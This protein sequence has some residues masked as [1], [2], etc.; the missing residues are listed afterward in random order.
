MFGLPND[1]E[2]S[3]VMGLSMGGYGALKC[4]LTYP[5]RYAGCASFSA[6]CDM[7][8]N[9]DHPEVYGATKE[10]TQGVFGLD[11]IIGPENDVFA[12]AEKSATAPEKPRFFVSCGTEDV[13]I[14]QN[15]KF[16]DF[17]REREYDVEFQEW[18]DGHTW[19]FWDASIEKAFRHFFG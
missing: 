13:F 2:H 10:E 16:R 12:L 7:Q 17:L 8:D 14:S 15:R 4:A 19:E 18:K 1:P 6:C 11:G 5:E 3:Y 9:A